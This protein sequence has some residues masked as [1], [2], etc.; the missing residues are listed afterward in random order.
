M[1]R[2]AAQ[3]GGIH[4]YIH[5]NIHTYIHIYIC[6]YIYICNIPYHS[7]ILT[8]DTVLRNG[9]AVHVPIVYSELASHLAL[10]LGTD[11]QVPDSRG[12]VG[13]LN[14]KHGRWGN[15]MDSKR[16]VES[17]SEGNVDGS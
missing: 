3:A 16:G 1:T 2:A 6:I 5:T 15:W 11:A 17:E 13:P 7:T 8:H 12:K 9:N 14:H 10:W 4:T